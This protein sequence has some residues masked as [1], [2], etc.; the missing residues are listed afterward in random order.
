MGHA[1]GDDLLRQI[2]ERIGESRRGDMSVVRFG[3]DEYAVLLTDTDDATVAGIAEA[4]LAAID[5]PF[6]IEDTEVRVSASIGVARNEGLGGTATDVLHEAD[7]AMYRA[8]QAGGDRI[9]LAW[10]PQ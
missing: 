7:A 2:A 1:A 5:Q 9:V 4:I 6:R 3:G 10:V 8:K